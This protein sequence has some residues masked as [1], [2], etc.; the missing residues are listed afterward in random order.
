[1]G[2]IADGLRH[3]GASHA[4]DT[5]DEDPELPAG[6]PL[7][8]APGHVGPHES[9]LASLIAHTALQEANPCRAM[10]AECPETSPVPGPHY[11][12]GDGLSH[13][14]AQY[15]KRIRELLQLVDFTGE[16]PPLSRSSS[17]GDAI[18]APNPP[19]L[20]IT[21]YYGTPPPDPRR[22]H[23]PWMVAPGHGIWVCTVCPAPTPGSNPRTPGL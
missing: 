1:M 20:G 4:A 12:E 14:L 16:V 13:L 17:E 15:A 23:T 8:G 18:L 10:R 6:G 7:E 19:G 11:L 5:F 21:V 3:P 22:E 9:C 2:D